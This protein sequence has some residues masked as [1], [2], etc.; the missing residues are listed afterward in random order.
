MVM[1]H[2]TLLNFRLKDSTYLTV[3]QH[4][5]F[6]FFSFFLIFLY[7][8]LLSFDTC[9]C[10]YHVCLCLGFFFPFPPS[11]RMLVVIFKI[12]HLPYNWSLS[13]RKYS[14]EC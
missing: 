11:G 3:W 1:F 7:F 2:F 6:G 14:I 9:I 10:L 5:F 8:Y 13:Y 4:A 12:F